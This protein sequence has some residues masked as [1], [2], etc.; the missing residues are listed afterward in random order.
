VRR[1]QQSLSHAILFKL[2]GFEFDST[3]S[4]RESTNAMESM[5]RAGSGEAKSPLAGSTVASREI[6]LPL[7]K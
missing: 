1:A 4:V 2:R 7:V 5:K 6:S 3:G